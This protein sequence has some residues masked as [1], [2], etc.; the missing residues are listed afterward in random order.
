MP[1]ALVLA[2]MQG[3]ADGYFVLPNTIPNYLA[4][5]KPGSVKSD[6]DS[7]KQVESDVML[8]LKNFST[9]TALAPT[10]TSPRTRSYHVGEMWDVQQSG[11]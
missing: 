11:S 9:L 7:F 4:E 5:Q 2:P 3:L 6:S 8:S 1:T 10:L